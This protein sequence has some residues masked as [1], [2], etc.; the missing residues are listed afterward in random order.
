MEQAV[1]RHKAAHPRDWPS[2]YCRPKGQ[3]PFKLRQK[4]AN[5][6]DVAL[7]EGRGH[8]QYRGA[9]QIAGAA[10]TTFSTPRL[11]GGSADKP[12]LTY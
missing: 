1:S 5:T 2:G 9:S 11:L 4:A 10:V 7:T 8:R 12:T 6:A 3:A